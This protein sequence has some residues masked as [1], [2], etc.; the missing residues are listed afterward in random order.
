VRSPFK[1]LIL[2][3]KSIPRGKLIKKERMKEKTK[4]EEVPVISPGS[5]P[6]MIRENLRKNRHRGNRKIIP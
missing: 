1:N 2:K 4:T 5:V 6:R 3:T